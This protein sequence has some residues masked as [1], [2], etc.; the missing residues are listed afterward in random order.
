MPRLDFRPCPRP[1]ILSPPSVHHLARKES[2]PQTN[3]LSVGLARKHRPLT[4]DSGPVYTASPFAFPPE[5][6]QDADRKL[7]RLPQAAGSSPEPAVCS[8]PGGQMSP[9]YSA[10]PSPALPSGGAALT[11][12]VPPG[13][14]L[15]ALV[16]VLAWPARPGTSILHH[17]YLTCSPSGESRRNRLGTSF[18]PTPLLRFTSTSRCPP[19]SPSVQLLPWGAARSPHGGCSPGFSPQLRGRVCRTRGGSLGGPQLAGWRGRRQGGEE[20]L[21]HDE[22]LAT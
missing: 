9:E 22:A 19:S 12:P 21:V 18:L 17:L 5:G 20:G 8:C 16:L 4:P 3:S 1:R 6:T 2:K 10:Q 13:R 15:S 11:V 7:L 14:P